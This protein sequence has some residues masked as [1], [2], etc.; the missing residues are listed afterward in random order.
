[1]TDEQIKAY[2][3]AFAKAATDKP[4]VV[5]IENEPLIYIVNSSDKERS[6]I[7]ELA[8][9]KTLDG[10]TCE[11]DETYL[12]ISCYHRAA[13]FNYYVDHVLYTKLSRGWETIIRYEDEGKDA[14]FISGKEELY[15]K[16]LEKYE[17]LCK[18][19]K[20]FLST[21]KRQKLRQQKPNRK[22]NNYY[23]TASTEGRKSPDR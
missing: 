13:A 16:Q 9:D 10:A 14:E 18:W 8:A 2:T 11:C 15:K 5:A 6:Y 12:H 22:D 17:T 4:L 1:M 21:P 20:Q 3:N 23:G 19:R 7:T